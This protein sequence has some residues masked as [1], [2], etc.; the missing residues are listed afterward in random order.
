[1][2]AEAAQQQNPLSILGYLVPMLVIMYFLMIRPQQKKAKEQALLLTKLKSGDR[3]VTSSGIV[4]T[5][6]AVKDKT[7]TVRTAGDTKLE[8]TKGSVTEIV[9]SGADSS[10][11]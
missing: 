10:E 4:G 11:A 7:V 6:T 9:A 2:L 8:F 3:V 1:M 5:I